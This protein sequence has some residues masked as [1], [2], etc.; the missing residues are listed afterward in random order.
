VT[1]IPP[2]IT[3]RGIDHSDALEAEIRERITWLEQF[4][5]D[6][7]GARVLVEIPHR[8]RHDGRHFHVRIEL[9]VPSGPPLVV[10]HEPSM[11]G[12]LKD[13]EEP[14]HHK[15]TEVDGVDRYVRV[16]VHRAFDAARR[17]LQDFAREQRGDVKRHEAEAP[18]AG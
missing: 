4:Y 6:I 14:E 13:I 11:H 17:R 16:A 5:P 8:H 3:F 7:M 15:A 1:L 18:E 2:Q 12:P 10:S 9:T